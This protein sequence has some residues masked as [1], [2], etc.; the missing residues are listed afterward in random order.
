MKKIIL[1]ALVVF[2]TAAI[3]SAQFISETDVLLYLNGKTF[4][5]GSSGDA[6]LSFKEM[7]SQMTVNGNYLMYQPDIKVVSQ[8]VAIVIYYGVQNP[9]SE[10]GIVVNSS[11]N[12]IID[13]GGNGSTYYSS[14]RTG[15]SM[16]PA[17]GTYKVTDI[18]ITLQIYQEGGRLRATIKKNGK[19]IT[20]NSSC[21]VVSEWI[22]GER[23]GMSDQYVSDW[24]LYN[25]GCE[26][27]SSGY[28]GFDID[29]IYDGIEGIYKIV[30]NVN[31]RI[32]MKGNS[33]QVVLK[34]YK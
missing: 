20:R 30:W 25:P 10:V 11:N 34:T 26:S 9:S 31:D 14:N 23:R 18:D 27:Q 15:G 29:I 1:I 3:T 33:F 32:I 4:I 22:E 19:L 17:I 16:S 13:G 12:T 7:G 21:G 2:C 24:Y 28:C 6:T 8:S 5:G